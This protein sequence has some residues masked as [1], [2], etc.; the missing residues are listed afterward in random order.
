M[1][2]LL[3]SGAGA[4]GKEALNTGMNILLD[5]VATNTSIGESFRSRVKESKESFGLK[6]EAE[7]KIY[8]L[9]VG[10][11]FNQPLPLSLLQLSEKYRRARKRREFRTRGNVQKRK[12]GHAK[13]IKKSQNKAEV[14]QN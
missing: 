14:K 11:G 6:R 8:K 13:I 5:V 9:M 3:K 1:L 12:R 2:P 4:V 7:E 10:S